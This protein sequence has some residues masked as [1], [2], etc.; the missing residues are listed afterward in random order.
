MTPWIVNPSAFNVLQAP[1]G[2]KSEVLI[3]PWSSEGGRPRKISV[4]LL[5][6]RR[7][8]HL[9][10][11]VC[12][13]A[14]EQKE[15]PTYV[16]RVMNLLSADLPKMFDVHHEPDWSIYADDV[17]F[18]DPMTKFDGVDQYR[19]NIRML[20]DSLLFGEGNLEIHDI[21][22]QRR[23]STGAAVWSV[24]TRFTL[25]FKAR[26]FP[27]KPILRFTGTS[28][29]ILRED[30]LVVGH[31]DRWDSI[32]NQSFPS[33]DALR[34]FSSQFFSFSS[35]ISISSSS[36]LLRRY[37][38]YE[39]R[40]EKERS[41]IYVEYVRRQDGIRALSEFA[42]GSNDQGIIIPTEA[43]LV[44]EFPDG[45]SGSKKRMHLFL[46]NNSSKTAT[47]RDQV[48]YGSLLEGNFA[49]MPLKEGITAESAARAATK[50]QNLLISG[51]WRLQSSR[52]W[53]VQFSPIHALPWNIYN[54]VWI[55]VGPS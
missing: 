20:K 16:T 3:A 7:G 15:V 10:S 31:I 46:R 17:E 14:V 49:C 45:V 5:G 37:E 25:S 27:W 19:R 42:A 51:G 29:Y 54:E 48:R 41:T 50:L 22:S 44:L 21:W 40:R 34:D 30:G 11:T 35:P 6:V 33:T 13:D 36:T 1:I 24:L 12:S 4:F 8:S 9:R 2:G 18:E 28:E 52:I 39:V 53:L 47:F 32:S 43:P 55:E 23:I 26:I 38:E